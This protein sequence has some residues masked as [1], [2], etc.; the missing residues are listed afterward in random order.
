MLILLHGRPPKQPVFPVSLFKREIDVSDPYTFLFLKRGILR[1]LI[2]CLLFFLLTVTVSLSRIRTSQTHSGCCHPDSQGMRE[3]QRGGLPGELG[4]SICQHNI[5]HKYLPQF[6]L[7]RDVLAVHQRRPE[8]I[9]VSGI[10][11]NI[12]QPR[13]T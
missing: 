7:P 9:Q 12:L 13:L 2:I 8:A 3:I 4:V 11:D 6:I 5:Q 1:G 10:I